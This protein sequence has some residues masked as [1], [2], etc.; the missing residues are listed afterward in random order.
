MGL[1]L[2]VI[3]IALPL[4]CTGKQYSDDLDQVVTVPET[5]GARTAPTVEMSRDDNW[6]GDL[7]DPTVDELVARALEGNLDMRS[8]WARMRQAEATAAQ[9]AAGLWPSLTGE[10]SYSRRRQQLFLPGNLAGPPGAGGGGG[11]EGE[12]QA[13]TQQIENYE[14]SVGASYEVDVWGRVAAQR[15]AAV[16]DVAATRADAEALAITLS[17]Q[18]SERWFDY[19]YQKQRVALIEDQIEVSSK[20]YELTVLQLGQGVASA[21]DVEQQKQQLESLQGQLTQARAAVEV[22][23]QQLAV[24]VGETPQEFTAPGGDAA[25]PDLEA[26]PEPGVPAD[27]LEQRP[28]LRAASLRLAAADERTLAAVRDRL[29]KLQLSA[30]IF[31]QAQT[32]A[33]LFDQLLWS[34]AASLSQPL[35]QGGRLNAAVARSEAS[36]EAQL[37]SYAQTLLQALRDV[38]VAMLQEE[39]QRRFLDS[40]GRQREAARRVLS[41]ARGRYRRGAATY[42]RVLTAIQSLQQLEQ[43]ILDARRQHIS[44]RIQLCRA[45][46]GGWTRDIEPL[47]QL[48]DPDRSEDGASE[49]GGGGGEGRS[50]SSGATAPPDGMRNRKTGDEAS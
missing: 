11:S 3:A 30:N 15:R 43:S 22:A 23:S 7:G 35:F 26:L 2:V 17:A 4:G 45:L 1:T 40:L 5:H 25:L 47:E 10:L 8:A 19:L 20:F 49:D 48:P 9:A 21:L 13:F 33:N 39:A 37:Y 14:A 50:D 24:L 28:D 6:C 16:L 12:T 34:I 29:P 27:L 38:R 44:R 46:G 41:L 36:A 31:L 42:F 32:L 18:I